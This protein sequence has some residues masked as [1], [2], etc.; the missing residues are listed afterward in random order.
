MHLDIDECENSTQY[1]CPSHSTCFN[2]EGGYECLCESDHFKN[3]YGIC[4]EIEKDSFKLRTCPCFCPA[5][6]TEVVR[7]LPDAKK[8]SDTIKKKLGIK[9]RKLI[10][11]MR[12]R[13]SA[14]DERGS[15]ASFG[16][17]ALTLLGLEFLLIT[18]GDIIVV[19][20]YLKQK[21]A[22]FIC[23]RA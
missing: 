1:T 20:Y 10:N 12:R 21:L 23:S 3:E 7:H 15:S 18:L 8:S 17:I 19:I 2:Q 6:V 4:E 5:M 14:R 13:S 9:T 16:I 11:T 22:E